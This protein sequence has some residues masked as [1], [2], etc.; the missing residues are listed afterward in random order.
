MALLNFNSYLVRLE[1]YLYLLGNCEMGYFNSY[2]VRLEEEAV[3]GYSH[4]EI[5]FNSYLVRLEV[6]N[7]R[8]NNAALRISIPT[9]CD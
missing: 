6:L 4:Q 1:G 5:Y 3:E 2:L 7:V 8:E 9:W